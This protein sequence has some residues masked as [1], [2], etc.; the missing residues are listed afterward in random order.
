MKNLA[1]LFILALTG[2]S[3]KDPTEEMTTKSNADVSKIEQP[4]IKLG[5]C[6][7]GIQESYESIAKSCAD[8]GIPMSISE[9]RLRETFRKGL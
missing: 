3:D 7:G 1:I 6:M 8:Q 5:K 4:C 9:E 2:C